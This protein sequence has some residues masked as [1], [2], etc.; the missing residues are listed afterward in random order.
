MLRTLLEITQ[1]KGRVALSE[2]E[3]LTWA[4]IV[5]SLL[6]ALFWV[7]LLWLME[8]KVKENGG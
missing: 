6:A 3:F 1:R 4:V 2:I 5:I 8:W 7:R